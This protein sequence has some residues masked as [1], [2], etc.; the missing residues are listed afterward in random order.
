[1]KLFL[2]LNDRSDSDFTDK[3]NCVMPNSSNAHD[4]GIVVLA[5][6]EEEAINLT[7]QYTRN[8]DIRKLKEDYFDEKIDTKPVII[9]LDK[10]GIVLFC[11]GNC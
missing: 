7:K 3:Y 2:W 4:G 8:C 9:P 5:E 1:M 10:K 11:N 6:S